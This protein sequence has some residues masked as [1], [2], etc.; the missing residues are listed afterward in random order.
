MFR[1]NEL[2]SSAISRDAVLPVLHLAHRLTRNAR[3]L[4]LTIEPQDLY[5]SYGGDKATDLDVI[6][7]C[8]GRFIIGEVKSSVTGLK[9][10]DLAKRGEVAKNIHPDEVVLGA[11]GTAWPD[12]VKEL[13]NQSAAE[14]ARHDVA[15]TPVL[16]SW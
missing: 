16:L 5:K 3:S 6:V 11:V 10:S 13:I 1:L 12:E 15:V 4:G 8:D 2:V 14:L 7:I 9:D